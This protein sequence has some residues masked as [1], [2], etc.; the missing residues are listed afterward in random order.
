MVTGDDQISERVDR[1]TE[2]QRE[3]L[4]LVYQ[5]MKSKDISRVVGVSP[6]TVDMRLRHAIRTLGVNSRIEAARLLAQHEQ[7]R[8]TYQ[9]AAYQSP[10]LVAPPH[11]SLDGRAERASD[12]RHSPTAEPA[13][14]SAST[15]DL[16][17]AG[18]DPAGAG[19]LAR[20]A[21]HGHPPRGRLE[22][23]RAP[24]D[25]GWSPQGDRGDHH[26]AQRSLLSLGGRFND[27]APH[28]RITAILAISAL[29]ALLAAGMVA[30]IMAL[31]QAAQERLGG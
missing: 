24:S 6:H 20:A 19:G 2:R 16:G 11:S 28:E 29:W 10:H 26:G 12:E 31:M 3:C 22:D 17:G 9:P 14:N 1:L 18:G 15:V 27:L 5:H 13:P 21:G 25:A 23:A 30:G 7:S 4:R 8:A